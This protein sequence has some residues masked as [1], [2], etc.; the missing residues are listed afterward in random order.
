VRPELLLRDHEAAGQKRNTNQTERP[1][2]HP[3]N[4]DRLH[5]APPFG[6][7]FTIPWGTARA[8]R[9]PIDEQPL[10]AGRQPPAWLR[11]ARTAGV[12]GLK[13]LRTD[14]GAGSLIS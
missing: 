6:C 11:Q 8:K 10:G 7:H 9:Q 4:F 2:N 3:L 5:D 14:I 1:A 13:D 12:R